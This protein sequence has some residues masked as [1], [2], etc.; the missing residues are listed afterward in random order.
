MH[1]MKNHCR[2]TTTN[3][4]FVIILIVR[5]GVSIYNGRQRDR[6][7]GK[8]REREIGRQRKRKFEQGGVDARAGGLR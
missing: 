7:R 8:Q 4:K 1:A 3:F 5:I 6:E 2:T